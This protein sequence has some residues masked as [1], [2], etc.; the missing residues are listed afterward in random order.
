MHEWYFR[1]TLDHLVW[2]VGMA[3]AFF[4]PNMDAGLARVEAL[5]ATQRTALKAAIVVVALMLMRMHYT[6][7]FSVDKYAYNALHPYTS[8]CVAPVP[9][10]ACAR[11]SAVYVLQMSMRG[12]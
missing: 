7:V 9:V 4:F 10:S 6:M 8:W 3:T 1:S 2:I 5:P 11:R 12:Q